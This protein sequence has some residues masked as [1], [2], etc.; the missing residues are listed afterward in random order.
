MSKFI[1]LN[2]FLFF[3]LNISGQIVIVTG[4]ITD[5]QNQRKLDDVLI[6]VYNSHDNSLLVKTMSNQNGNFSIELSQSTNYII[7][8]SRQAYFEQE[9]VFYCDDDQ[10]QLNVGMQRM[11]GY[12]FEATVKELLSFKDTQLGKELTNLK[13]EIYNRT[14]G[15][16]VIV[17]DNDPRNSFKANF[18]RGNKYVILIRKKGYF[19]KRIEVNVDIHGCILCFEGLG[20]YSSPEIESELTESNTKGS[21]I[22]DIAMKKIIKDEAIVLDNIYYDYNKSTIRKDAQPAL[23]SLVRMLKRNPI[24]IELS[25]HTD[26]RG[27]DD[28]NLRLSEDR[29]KTAVAYI[30]SKGINT[31]RISAKGY[32]ETMLLNDC[33]DGKP[34]DETAHQLNRRTEFKVTGFVEQS[35]FDNKT[36]EEIILEENKSGKRSREIIEILN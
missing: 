1:L 16:S 18:E 7:K 13:V 22:T 25:A 2:L 21:I 5:S 32:G 11:P 24:I 36:L 30:V 8:Y 27:K 17:V 26:S 3:S 6:E 4:S 15:K 10:I 28:Y 35:S 31:R 34:C 29:A 12:E 33:G 14:A 23:N 19:A 20:T 9:S